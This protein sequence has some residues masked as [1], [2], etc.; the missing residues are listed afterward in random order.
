LNKN[1]GFP[2][3]AYSNIFQYLRRETSPER[4]TTMTDSNYKFVLADDHK[5]NKALVVIKGNQTNELIE[6]LKEIDDVNFNKNAQ[7]LKNVI[8][9]SSITKKGGKD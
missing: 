3:L 7:E 1:N 9:S 6:Q 8:N 4:N 5:G 2:L